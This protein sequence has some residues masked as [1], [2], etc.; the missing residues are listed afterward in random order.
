VPG[1]RNRQSGCRSAAANRWAALAVTTRAVSSR[2][3][4]VIVVHQLVYVADFVDEVVVLLV[5]VLQAV[6]DGLFVLDGPRGLALLAAH[7]R[8][9]A[10]VT[11]AA[12]GV[13]AWRAVV[14]VEDARVEAGGRGHC[15]RVL[16]VG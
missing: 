5:E 3:A 2:S 6:L 16:V 12:A 4:I 11:G 8:E 9:L 14:C 15:V 10:A 7:E 1:P 13:V